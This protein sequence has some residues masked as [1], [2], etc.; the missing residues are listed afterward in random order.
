MEGALLSISS[1]SASISG[2][3]WRSTILI[4]GQARVAQGDYVEGDKSQA[5]M[6]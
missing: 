4:V 1:I 3:C 5:V 2:W 6:T